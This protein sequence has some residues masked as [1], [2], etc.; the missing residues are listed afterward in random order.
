MGGIWVGKNLIWVMPT[1]K[2]ILGRCYEIIDLK[3]FVV[4]KDPKAFLLSF[5][6]TEVI[7][8]EDK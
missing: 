6:P 3:A 7:Q 8:E 4:P 2:R 5:L 1:T